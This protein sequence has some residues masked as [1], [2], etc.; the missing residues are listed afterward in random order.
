MFELFVPFLPTGGAVGGVAAYWWCKDEFKPLPKI[1]N[2]LSDQEKQE[3]SDH[4]MKVLRIPQW[5]DYADLFS[6]V[7][8]QPRL[9]QQ[10]LE[11]LTQFSKRNEDLAKQPSAVICL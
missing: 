3:L 5:R 9:K 11:A 8:A 1:L 4:I 7:S 6:Q 2:E 10:I